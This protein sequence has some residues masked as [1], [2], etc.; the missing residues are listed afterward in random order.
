M[1]FK[2]ILGIIGAVGTLTGGAH[3]QTRTAP[4]PA[5]EALLPGGTLPP[6]TAGVPLPYKVGFEPAEG[7]FVGPLNGQQGW[8]TFDSTPNQ[9]TVSNAHPQSGSQ[10]LRLVDTP[11][12]ADTTLSGGFSPALPTA[13]NERRTTS[14]GISIN[15]TQPGPDG[16]AA[17]SVVGQ[18]IGPAALISFRVTFEFTG[19]VL[20]VDDVNNDDVLEFVDTG[21]NWTTDNYMKLHVFHNPAQDQIAYFLNDQLIYTSVD[22]IFAGTNV[23]QAVLFSDNF[24]LAGESADFDNLAVFAPLAGDANAD[25]RVN[26]ADFNI[27][28]QNFGQSSGA[29]WIDA[30][31]NGDG[32]V[33]LTD[34]NALAANFGL[35]VGPQGP[36]VEDWAALGSAVV[37]E[38]LGGF[39]GA[40]LAISGLMLRRRRSFPR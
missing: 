2:S 12:V 19:D 37:P 31:F 26:L 3:A 5:R 16:G 40:G 28:A 17:Y 35:S 18:E 15:N 34:F 22:G 36:D 32:I 1:A 39:A 20:V 38:P 10:H 6:G 7:Y 25:G 13:P 24:F 11:S 27:L 23:A 8:T 9:P 14:V 21:A 33:N 29:T 4:P 30:D